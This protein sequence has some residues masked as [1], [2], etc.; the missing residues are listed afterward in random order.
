M[1]ALCQ[2]SDD[3][4]AIRTS[5]KITRPG[6]SHRTRASQIQ[7]VILQLKKEW[8][9]IDNIKRKYFTTLLSFDKKS[10]KSLIFAGPVPYAQDLLEISFCKSFS[11]EP[12]SYC[13]VHL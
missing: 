1:L 12:G 9:T 7:Q 8:L 10:W 13:I 5:G 3:F 2:Y 11:Y 4:A 6:Y